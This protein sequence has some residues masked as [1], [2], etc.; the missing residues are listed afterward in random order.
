M[1][2]LKIEKPTV[3]EIMILVKEYYNK[4]WNWSWWNLHIVL[5]DWNIKDGD[6]NFCIERANNVNDIDWA[7]IAKKL[8][9][10]S[11]TQRLKVYNNLYMI[12][13]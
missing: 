4:E 3:A 6:I 9:Q 10:M 7:I 13:H 11:K 12:Y 2:N 5:D 8:L 1:D